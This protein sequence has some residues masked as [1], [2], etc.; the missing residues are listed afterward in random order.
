MLISINVKDKT[1]DLS[2]MYIYLGLA[3]NWLLFDPTL[4]DNAKIHEMWRSCLRNCSCGIAITDLRS[5]A[6]KV[7]NKCTITFAPDPLPFGT[8]ATHI[9]PTL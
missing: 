7:S 8:L 4:K 9:Y 5:Y 1:C 2:K 6:S 3:E